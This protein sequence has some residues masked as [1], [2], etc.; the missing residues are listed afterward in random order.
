MRRSAAPAGERQPGIAGV[1]FVEIIELLSDTFNDIRP[2]FK[3]AFI[4]TVATHR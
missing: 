2:S 1:R 3:N 4:S